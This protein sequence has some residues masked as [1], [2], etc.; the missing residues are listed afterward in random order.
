MITMANPQ[1]RIEFEH[2]NMLKI[3]NVWQASDAF[4]VILP[5]QWPVLVSAHAQNFFS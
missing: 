4:A 5:Q 1:M 2:V 3:Q